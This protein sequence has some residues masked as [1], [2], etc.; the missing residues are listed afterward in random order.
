[1]KKPK[2]L[3]SVVIKDSTGTVLFRKDFIYPD[4]GLDYFQFMIHKTQ[5]DHFRHLFIGSDG[6]LIEPYCLTVIKD[7]DNVCNQYEV[8]GE[9]YINKQFEF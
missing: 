3:T 9:A 2:P 1:M 7:L 8:V 6:K 4:I 5:A